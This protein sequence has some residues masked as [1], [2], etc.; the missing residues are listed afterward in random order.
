MGHETGFWSHWARSRSCLSDESHPLARDTVAPEEAGRGP[1]LEVSRRHRRPLALALQGVSVSAAAVAGLQ[2]PL[3]SVQPCV[4]SRS[5]GPP[6][7]LRR[8]ERSSPAPAMR[9]RP[10]ASQCLSS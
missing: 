10:S 8:G 5:V 2:D 6:L 1:C 3:G 4:S 7:T 9:V